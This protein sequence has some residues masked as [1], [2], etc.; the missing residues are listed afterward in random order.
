M[1]NLLF[2]FSYEVGALDTSNQFVYSSVCNKALPNGRSFIVKLHIWDPHKNSSTYTDMVKIGQ[3]NRLFHA[4]PSILI[5]K[6]F[7]IETDCI[8]NM[9]DA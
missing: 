8:P 2:V 7:I 5:H 9:V 4:E 3:N 6:L 1:T